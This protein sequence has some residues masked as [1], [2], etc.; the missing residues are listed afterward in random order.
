MNRFIKIIGITGGIGSGKSTVSAVLHD[1][2][3]PII[4]LDAVARELMTPPALGYKALRNAFPEFFESNG[5]INRNSMRNIIF[6]QPKIRVQVEKIL[7]PLIHDAAIIKISKINFNNTSNILGIEAPLIHPE[8]IWHK[9]LNHILVV[10]C[11]AETQ[12]SRVSIRNGLSKAE[13]LPIIASQIPRTDRLRLADSVI[14]N[15]N[16]SEPSLRLK[17]LEWHSMVTTH[18]HSLITERR[19]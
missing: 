18:H 1:F 17:T 9:K 7:H 11:P 4:D 8:S 15:D 6:S 19:M 3:M 5:E 16:L 13:I 12:I 2:G 14:Y 10:D